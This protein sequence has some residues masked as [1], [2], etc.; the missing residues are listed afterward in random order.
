MYQYVTAEGSP[1]SCIS[2]PPAVFPRPTAQTLRQPLYILLIQHGYK[3]KTVA[4]EFVVNAI[5]VCHRRDKTFP[6]QLPGQLRPRSV[7]PSS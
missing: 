5:L 2:P 7:N 6:R 4:A 1:Y 3:R